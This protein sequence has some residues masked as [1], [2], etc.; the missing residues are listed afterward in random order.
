LLDLSLISRLAAVSI[1]LEVPF[2]LILLSNKIP[3][4]ELTDAPMLN[5]YLNGPEIHQI[6]NL[7]FTISRLLYSLQTLCRFS[8]SRIQKIAIIL[9]EGLFE[10]AGLKDW[11][12]AHCHW[13]RWFEIDV[14]DRHILQHL[15]ISEACTQLSSTRRLDFLLM[16]SI[17]TLI[18]NREYKGIIG[19]ILLCIFNC[20]WNYTKK[21]HDW[22]DNLLWF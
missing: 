18:I 14:G 7:D 3:T 8:C 15:Y 9:T 19:A 17:P 13:M 1:E 4:T 16:S 12:N 5:W 6:Y 20:L 2:Y 11:Y 22:S 10:L 21:W